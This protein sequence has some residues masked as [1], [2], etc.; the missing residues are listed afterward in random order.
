MLEASSSSYQHER[1]V[2][3]TPAN[4]LDWIQHYQETCISWCVDG[5]WTIPGRPPQRD[6]TSSRW[7]ALGRGQP[8]VSAPPPRN[9]ASPLHGSYFVQFQADSCVRGSRCWQP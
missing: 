2:F 9:L 8:H 5:K 4:C 6:A 1:D 7:A 3:T